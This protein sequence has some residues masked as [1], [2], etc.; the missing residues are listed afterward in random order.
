M[1]M[2][3]EALAA[4]VQTTPDAFIA[5]RD[6][7][8]LRYFTG[9]MVSG[10]DA[11][12]HIT[13]EL[14]PALEWAVS[15]PNARLIVTMPPRHSKSLHVSENLPAWYLGKHPTHRIIAASHTAQLAYTFSRR[16]R[17]KMLDSRYPFAV[18][19]ADDKGAVQAWDTSE[20]GGYLAVGAGGAP[21]GHGGNGII[22]DDPIRSA[23]DA[24]SATVRDA[25]WEWYQGTIRTR[26]EPNGWIIVTAT[27][28]HEDDLTGRLLAEMEQG[29]E[30]WRHVHLEAINEH[31]AALWPERWPID[32]LADIKRAVGSRAWEAQY[33]GR[34][35]PSEGGMFKRGWWQRYRTLPDIKE[36]II[37]VDSA[38]KEGV[39]NDYSALGLWGTDGQGSAYL[40]RVWR[41]RVAFPDLIRLG[42]D[43][44]NYATNLLPRLRIP[45]IVEDKASGQSAIQ[46]WKKQY[47]TANGVLPALPV[48]PFTIKGHQSKVARAEGVT[49]LVEGGR[50]FIPESAPWVDDFLTEHEQFPTGK[51][52]DQVD[53]TSMALTRLELKPR[54]G[55]GVA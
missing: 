46:V 44:H 5:E 40:I 55:F 50:V 28:W 23:A 21:T 25:L 37:T 31:G 32:A 53:M 35:V 49:P 4:D 29:G 51:H 8:R 17:N 14:I 7:R 13:N 52:D 45:L 43:A 42:H 2:T 11:A 30:Q 6:R 16:V 48:V 41:Q 24:D 1:S 22:I 19:V 54:R 27:R 26:L 15:T 33:Q 9:R 38:F 10:Y 36:A 12:P 47:H 34:P 39:E 20:G 3:V 18:T